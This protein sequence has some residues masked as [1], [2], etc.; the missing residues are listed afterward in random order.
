MGGRLMRARLCLDHAHSAEFDF[1]ISLELGDGD[2]RRT[3]CVCIDGHAQIDC[4][5]GT[6]EA[7]WIDAAGKGLPY[8]LTEI[9]GLL[10]TAIMRQLEKEYDGIIADT[11]C[12]FWDSLEANHADRENDRAATARA[13]DV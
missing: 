11:M 1:G 9:D 7:I 12:R 4:N 5:N 13:F 2:K 6:I 10:Y 3:L 8:R